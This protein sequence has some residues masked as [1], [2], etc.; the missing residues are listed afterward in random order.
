MRADAVYEG[1]VLKLLE[2]LDL[3][4]NEHVVV[5]VTRGNETEG[6]PYVDVAFTERLRKEMESEP[7]APSIEEVREIMSTIPGNW[8]EDVIAGRGEY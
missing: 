8:S 6:K 5:S 4:E 1:G 7:P 3:E 2:P